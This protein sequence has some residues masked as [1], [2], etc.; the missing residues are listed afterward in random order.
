MSNNNFNDFPKKNE[1]NNSIDYVKSLIYR[2]Q[3]DGNLKDIPQLE[4]L[5]QLLKT[6]KYGLVWEEHLEKVEKEMKTKIP[7]FI[8]DKGKEIN[9]SDSEKY[10]FLLEGDNLHSLHLL[11]KTSLG[12]IDIIYIDPPY[13]TGHKDFKYND[14]FVK[15]D[16][17]YKHSKWLSFMASR[18]KIAK[19][20][21]SKDGII[22]ISI[23]DNEQSQL[24]LLMDDIFGINSFVSNL[25]IETSAVAGTRRYAAINGSVVK[26][27]EFV[28]VYSNNM[29]VS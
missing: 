7:I 26:T 23:D 15:K 17:S 16:D 27:A 13:N 20:L 12:K 8:E 21:L 6:K 24:K 1:R 11:E 9:N 3:N 28:L 5:I 22:F 25:H 10:D 2:A 29:D 19:R 14:Y 4:K 18:L